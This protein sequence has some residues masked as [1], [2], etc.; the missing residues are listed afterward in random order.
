[1]D[2]NLRIGSKGTGTIGCGLAPSMEALIAARAV[3][4]M[5]GGGFVTRLFGYVAWDVDL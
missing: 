2:D 5:G 4:G 1:M 3:A